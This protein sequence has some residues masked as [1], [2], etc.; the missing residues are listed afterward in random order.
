MVVCY[1]PSCMKLVIQSTFFINIDTLKPNRYHL[2]TTFLHLIFIRYQ[3]SKIDTE[4][5]PL[6]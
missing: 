4:L 3:V 6:K 2:D 5:A 1:P